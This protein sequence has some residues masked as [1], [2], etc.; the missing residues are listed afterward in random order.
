M[1]SIWNWIRSRDAAT[2]RLLA[3][4]ALI[5]NH[6][7]FCTAKNPDNGSWELWIGATLYV[8]TALS[9]VALIV[10]ATSDRVSPSR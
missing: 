5:I 10:A 3:I 9:L 4:A 2:M 1:T 8:V 6:V 7:G